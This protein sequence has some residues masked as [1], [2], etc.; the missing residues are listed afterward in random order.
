MQ[1][2]NYLFQPYTY[3]LTTQ[4]LLYV[5]TKSYTILAATL[6]VGRILMT[7]CLRDAGEPGANLD[8]WTS[9]QL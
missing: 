9:I 1:N 2:R 3:N 4:E 5:E 6:Q 7:S 8:D